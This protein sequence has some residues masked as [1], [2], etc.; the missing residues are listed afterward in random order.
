MLPLADATRNH[1]SCR[2]D[3]R[4]LC[5]F[6]F[7]HG[8]MAVLDDPQHTAFYKGH[9]DEIEAAYRLGGIKA[10]VPYV[11]EAEAGAE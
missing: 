6:Y 3:D 5:A 1:E 2:C 8:N 11:R 10:L 9:K 4:A 7:L